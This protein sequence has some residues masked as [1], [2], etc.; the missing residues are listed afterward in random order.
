KLVPFWQLKLYLMDALGKKDFYKDLY[1]YMRNHDN[2]GVTNDG[3]YQL[4]FVR[5]SCKIANLDLTDF[6]E[7]WGFLTPIDRD[8]SDYA[9][10]RFTIT[11][12]EIDALKSEIATKNYPKP[13]HND[14]YKITD[15]NVS[16]YK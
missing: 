2:T 9:T 13:K 12:E 15:D 14:I 5:A 6:F 3:Y 7:D 11:Q 4:D 10:K 16:D 8:I 1:E